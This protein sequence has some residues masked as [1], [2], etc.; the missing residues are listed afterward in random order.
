[1][2]VLAVLSLAAGAESQSVEE[3][4]ARHVEALGGMKN[5][6]AIRSIR[7]SGRVVAGGGREALVMREIARPG[8]VRT[9]FTYQ[10]VTGVYAYDGERGWNLSPFDGSFEPARMADDEERRTADQADFEGPLVDWKAK[11]HQV[12]LAGTETVDGREVYKLEVTLRNGR[13]LQ[14]FLDAQSLLLVRS[15]TTR[16]VRGHSIQVDT[17]FEDYREAAGVLFAHRIETGAVGRPRRLTVVI[18]AIEVNPAIED[19][20]FEIPGG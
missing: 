14:Q 17:E 4:L 15:R 19:S 11:G 7:M 9:E 8:R 16:D 18:D 2:L 12:S 1:M 5:L 20:R 3:I 10:G 6:R 13:V